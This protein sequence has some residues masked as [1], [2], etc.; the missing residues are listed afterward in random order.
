[1][2][3]TD[4]KN[5]LLV[6]DEALIASIEKR[7]LE[8]E[9]YSVTIASSGEEGVDIIRGNSLKVDLVLMDIDLGSG[10][11]GTVAAVE[12]LKLREIPVVF[13]SSHTEREVVQKTE[14]IT[15]YGY[16]VKDSGVTVLDASIKMAFK[17]F[18]AN[19]I[20]VEKEKELEDS[21]EKYRQLYNQAG[22]AICYFTLDG[23]IISFNNIALRFHKS[24]MDELSGKT[25]YDL[26]PEEKAEI[27]TKRIIS[28]GSSAEKHEYEDQI[29]TVSGR[30]WFNT[31]L[32]T[33][34]DS[35]GIPTG[36]QVILK[37]V[38]LEKRIREELNRTNSN[39]EQQK[40][41]LGILNEIIAV[42]NAAE[43]RASLFA[44]V[45]EAA[46]SL[47]GYDAGGIYIVDPGGCYANVV[48]S[49]NL[50]DEFIEKAGTV[51]ITDSRYINLFKNGIPVITNQYE[52]I[53]AEYAGL[54]G[55]CSVIG[56]PL[57][58]KN[59]IIGS[60]N[61]VS[62]QR[63]VV[64]EGESS[65][66]MAIGRELGT[67]IK[68]ISAEEESKRVVEN[69]KTLF[70]SVDEMIFIFNL[71]GEII[72]T[73]EP[74]KKRLQYS[75]H[76]LMGKNPLFL[77]RPEER[78]RALQVIKRVLSL[79]TDFFYLPFVAKD[80]TL[81]DV[82]TKITRGTWDDSEVII[83]VS[84]DVSKQKMAER[85]LEETEM[86]FA[87]LFDLASDGLLGLVFGEDR[88]T[89]ANRMICEM[90]G[91]S[92][93][94]LLQLGISDIHPDYS[95]NHVMEQYEGLV[96]GSFAVARDI[97]VRRRDGGIFYADIAASSFMLDGKRCVLGSFRNTNE[98][99]KIEEN[100]R[101]GNERFSKAFRSSPAPLA[102]TDMEGMFIDVNGEWIKM[103]GYGAG[104][105]TGRT[106]DELGILSEPGAIRI[107]AAGV[108]RDGY[109]REYPIKLMTKD[110][111]ERDVLWSVE[112]I[113][114]GGRDA[115]L[116]LVYDITD[117]YTAQKRIMTL[118]DEKELILR[119]M[120]HRL[121]NNMSTISGLLSYQASLQDDNRVSDVLYGAS[122]RIRGMMLLYNKLYCIKAETELPA[123]VYLS[124]LID[125]IT[126]IFPNSKNIKV[127]T[128]I[129]EF[130]MNP[131]LVTTTGILINELVSNS[132]K[133][134]FNGR[135]N[136]EICISVAKQSDRVV[137]SYRDDGP[138]IPCDVTFDRS[139][140]FGMQL[141]SMLVKQMKGSAIIEAPDRSRVIIEFVL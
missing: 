29:D 133:Y 128:E 66:L 125:E 37:E 25:L 14:N 7:L 111:E 74:V 83:A 20:L 80:G 53:S 50:S 105:I 67:I 54:T 82:E 3:F 136:G 12:I 90:L 46:L 130:A 4:R 27:Y 109:V 72:R 55:F 41:L 107:I 122:E 131:E 98:R 108:W 101:A 70:D 71:N 68:R 114:I 34:T 30:R 141:V 89:I 32:S 31:L 87:M 93:D 60:L 95:L 132:M 69:I 38:T 77:H 45:L 121:K 127:K 36:V 138:G 78:E 120:N 61:L 24:S 62:R 140:G 134:A 106:I 123:Q 26:Y 137:I 33:V 112:V 94:E 17:L 10:I 63:Y 13:L 124:T 81:I 16:V 86:R 59:R 40:R 84:R 42:A 9:G 115:M 1:M 2:N 64:T 51:S 116:S 58:S 75:E 6:E 47:L 44:N 91:Y 18:D 118:L 23:E 73:N 103:T 92:R 15:S 135:E 110:G 139:P 99:K 48:C 126:G 117:S 76:E 65:T 11:D 102:I 28:Q 43:D 22:L 39:L 104:E 57:Y 56:I 96:N 100:L 97:P 129:D 85:A 5:I 21:G 52:K 35:N 79:E 113:V 8:R 49:R 119:E 19:K 88:F